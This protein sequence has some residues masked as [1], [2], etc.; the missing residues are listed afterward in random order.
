MS[1]DHRPPCPDAAA[2]DASAA[3]ALAYRPE[4]GWTLLCNGSIQFDDTGA[5]LPDGRTVAPQDRI[6]DAC[7]RAA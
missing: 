3:V 4:Q 2:P 6:R 1:C 5:C 7:E